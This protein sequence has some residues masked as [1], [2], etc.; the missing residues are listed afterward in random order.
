[1]SGD[2]EPAERPLGERRRV[3][4]LPDDLCNQI[5]AGEVV[6]RPASVVKE[7]VENALDA[8][9]RR[10][11]VDIESGGLALIRVADDGHG[12][13]QKDAL[14]ATLRHATSKIQ[15]LD[16]LRR[17]ESFGFR[18]EALPSIAS[19]SRFVL[20]TRRAE[21]D[22]GSEITIEG[23]GPAAAK[24]CGSAAGTSI[25][26]RE[27]FF[28]T[29]AR[30]KFLKAVGTEAAHVTEVVQAAALAEPG[31]TVL[32]SRDGRVAREWLRAG[33]REERVRAM[34]AGEALAACRRP[35]WPPPGGGVGWGAP[36]APPRARG[37][38]G[39]GPPPPRAPPGGGGGAGGVGPPCRRQRK[40]GIGR[41]GSPL[42]RRGRG[43]GGE[44]IPAPH[45]D[46]H[47]A[48]GVHGGGVVHARR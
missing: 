38:G 27:L 34:L 21:D 29:P 30:R 37:R 36:R 31:V 43:A 14:L 9:A 41:V 33:S 11:V 4:V 28:N 48:G 19:V 42:S 5:A 44:G 35:R 47:L 1:M 39:G 2:A 12:M 40:R 13:D 3:R 32:L 10:V 45:L 26:V 17:I 8:G 15:R 7:L 24:P 6:E 25:E 18:G 20:R 22:E 46:H 23:G 16:D